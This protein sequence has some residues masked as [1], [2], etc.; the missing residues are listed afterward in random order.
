M[1]DILFIFDLV[2]QNYGDEKPALALLF[3]EK[4]HFMGID[5]EDFALRRYKYEVFNRCFSSIIGYYCCYKLR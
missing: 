1:F 3:P 5:K 4:Y 2:D